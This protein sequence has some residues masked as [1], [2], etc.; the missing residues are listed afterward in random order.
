MN[1][2]I[3]G[4]RITMADLNDDDLRNQRVIGPPRRRYRDL[5]SV[6]SCKSTKSS[7]LRGMLSFA[8][9]P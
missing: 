3:E 6:M 4:L 1:T 5:G 9:T 2:N 7:K 8:I